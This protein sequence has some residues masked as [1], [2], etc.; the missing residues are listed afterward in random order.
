[1]SSSS[2]SSFTIGS[3]APTAS[4]RSASSCSR[5]G[6]SRSGSPPR[7]GGHRGAR[8]LGL[9]PQLV[10]LARDLLDAVEDVLLAGPARRELVATGLGLGEL[11]LDRLA[12]GR[13]LLRHRGEL[14]LELR[15]APL[16]LVELDRGAVDLHPQPRGRLVD[17]VDRLVRQESGR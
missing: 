8:P 1:M 11:A 14:D 17:E 12:H 16:G 10:D 3:T 7:A 4:P 13:R 2:T 6:S 15:H 9:H 5:A